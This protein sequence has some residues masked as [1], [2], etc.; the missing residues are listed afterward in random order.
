MD[1]I[2]TL[3][4]QFSIAVLLIE[5]DMKLV[6]GICDKIIVLNY[7]CVIAEGCPN[8]IRCNEDVINAYLGSE[9]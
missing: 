5:H 9:A 8:D 1:R 7:G 3:R 4:E 2:N 6:M